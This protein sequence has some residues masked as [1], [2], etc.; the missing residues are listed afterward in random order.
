MNF[1][2]VI[3]LVAIVSDFILH[4]WKT[5]GSPILNINY[6]S[7]DLA[8]F[9]FQSF[10]SCNLFG[11]FIVSHGNCR[12]RY[13]SKKITQVNAKN[14]GQTLT[15]FL[16]EFTY[17]QQHQCSRRKHKVSRAFRLFTVTLHIFCNNIQS[18]NVLEIL[19]VV[20]RGMG[21]KLRVSILSGKLW[22][23][24]LVNQYTPQ[25]AGNITPK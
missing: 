8:H 14:K 1:I 4:F 2:A 11:N 9:S 24:P 5:T 23:H 20:K 19:G 3:I 6:S 22:G 7:L 18:W 17:S 13:A 15:P 25:A 16:P 12:T 21:L 10:I